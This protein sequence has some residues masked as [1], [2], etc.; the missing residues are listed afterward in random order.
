MMDVERDA[1]GGTGSARRRRERRLRST[2]RHERMSVAM[3]FAES[4]HHS[5]QRQKT[6]RAGERRHELYFTATFRK[7]LLAQGS[8]A[9]CLGEPRGPQDQD[10]L[11]NMDQAAACAPMV[12]ILDIPVP[13]LVDQLSEVPTIFSFSSLQ[14]TT[15]Q[16][17]DIPVRGRGGRNVDGGGGGPSSGLQGFSSGQSSTATLSSKKRISERIVEQIVD[18]VSSGRLLG[19]LP[20]QGSSSSHSPAGVEELADEPGESV[21]SHFSPNQKKCEIGFALES[22][23]AR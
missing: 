2:L 15:E 22:W 11:R 17:V 6:A 20:G 21:F 4:T 5:A 13:Q 14:R 1:G 23:S 19:S 8:R 3:A 10:Q 9:P 16:H 18:P 12:Q 7:R